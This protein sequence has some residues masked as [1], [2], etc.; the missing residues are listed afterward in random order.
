MFFGFPAMR[1]KARQHHQHQ[2]VNAVED[3]GELTRR[4]IGDPIQT[5]ARANDARDRIR[6]HLPEGFEDAAFRFR[7]LRELFVFLVDLVEDVKMRF[8]MVARRRFSLFDD[9][10]DRAVRGGRI[11]N[12]D[13]P[14]REVEIGWTGLVV[15]IADEEPVRIDGI[16]RGF[17]LL[18]ELADRTEID[19]EGLDRVLLAN[20]IVVV[21]LGGGAAANVVAERAEMRRNRLVGRHLVTHEALDQLV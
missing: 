9:T 18:V 7:A 4:G 20:D 16:E 19:V 13:Q 2:L 12:A 15:G 6:E 10:L 14:S 3:F 5:V 11:V 1:E 17:D 21:D 8:G